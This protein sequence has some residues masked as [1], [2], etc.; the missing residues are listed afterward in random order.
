[1]AEFNN[2]RLDYGNFSFGPDSG[3]IY[4]I[5][6]TTNTMLVKNDPGGILDIPV[7]LVKTIPLS[8]SL[9]NEV[10]TLEYDGAYFWTQTAIGSSESSGTF[11]EKWQLSDTG[12]TLVKVPGAGNEFSL[13]NV[14]SQKYDSDAMCIEVLLRSLSDSV[15]VGDSTIT[16]SDTSQ[17]ELGDDVYIG[18]NS[19][20]VREVRRV[21]GISSNVLTLD[22]NLEF[23]YEIGDEVRI[24]KSLWVFNNYNRLDPR[25]GQ[26]RE[27][28]TY[29][30]NLISSGSSVEWRGV[31]AATNYAG[32]LYYVRGSQ[33]LRY[34]P[35]GVDRGY[36][37]SLLL[38]NIK[39][40]NSSIITVSDLQVTGTEIHKLQQ[41]IHLFNS[42]SKEFDDILSTDDKYNIEREFFAA[43]V[44]SLTSHRESN[45]VL[46]GQS[47]QSELT[48]E[49]RDQ[50]FVPIFGRAVTVSEDDVSGFIVPGYESFTTDVQGKGTTIYDSGA[51]PQFSNPTVTS[52]DLLTGINLKTS[53]SQLEL[54]DN[55]S[56]LEQYESKETI[57][58]IDQRRFLSECPLIQ[59][60]KLL[61]ET[62]LEQVQERKSETL[63]TQERVYN[64]VPILQRIT[65]KADIHIEQYPF[66]ES[67]TSIIQ[68]LFL[69][70]AIPAAY[71]QKNDPYTDI[72][73][74]IV[75]Y[76]SLELVVSTLVFKVNG[77]DVTGL[78]DVEAFPGGLQLTYNNPGRFDYGSRVNVSI[79]IEDNNTPANLISTVYY[80]DIVRDYLKP[81]LTE[82]FPPDNSIG[83]SSNT[84][85]YA[86]IEDL[87]TGIDNDSIEM[88]VEGRLVP[89]T[90]TQISDTSV[91]VSYLTTC[92]YV[93]QSKVTASVTA[94]DVTGN[95]FVGT[96]SFYIENSPGVFYVSDVP[97]NCQV[98]VPVETA[99]CSEVFG[100]EEGVR[101]SAMDFDINGQDVKYVIKP[102]VYRKE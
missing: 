3:R 4:S 65:T 81:E 101:I 43:R 22:S 47:I 37:A 17:V 16:I 73:V 23:S 20:D 40:D 14:S 13:V 6:H 15:L 92:S 50:Y 48:I 55:V 76:G 70:A 29:T 90:L 94:S 39:N 24:R 42:S 60:E 7:S 72:V 96:W 26:L 84:E 10:R 18:P 69:I 62:P 64:S 100:L 80:F 82:V 57:T 66:I 97:E 45:S 11:I 8:S 9:Y 33:L 30:G 87:E 41:E 2:A 31:T 61:V 68:Y 56:Y 32:S 83:N 1:M 51:N 86:I 79:E 28:S 63:I 25:S 35:H 85:V 71:S 49:M 88:Y 52:E 99:L 19:S 59:S 98:L 75:G 54:I 12:N 95:K 34:K 89:H 93:Y 77:A 46:F 74:R 91:K 5:D 27:Y 38:E 21:I 58:F 67:N 44:K 102:K 36:R 78:V 53:L